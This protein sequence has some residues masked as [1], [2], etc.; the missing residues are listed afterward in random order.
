MGGN[1]Y[2]RAAAVLP[3]QPDPAPAGPRGF[4]DTRAWHEPL[5]RFSQV[6]HLTVSAYNAQAERCL[7]PYFEHREQP[8]AKMLYEAGHWAPHGAATRLER[9]LARRAMQDGVYCKVRVGGALLLAAMP[10]FGE[11]KA[12]VGALVFGWVMG[13]FADPLVCEHLARRFNLQSAALWRAARLTSPVSGSKLR[14]NA[15]LLETL[16]RSIAYQVTAS[17]AKDTFLATVSHE[18]RT[19][20]TAMLLRAQGLKRSQHMTHD[21]DQRAL[22]VIL[23]SASVQQKLIE[24]LLDASRS[25]AGNLI[26]ET[27][28]CD[29]AS[30]LRAA[31]D[32]VSTA[33]AAK[34]I[35]LNIDIAHEPLL[36]QAD[37]VR[38]QQ[39]F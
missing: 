10:V 34:N 1:L 27:T 25:T 8:L 38:L 9:R 18:L 23:Q 37:P 6:T 15:L 2:D 33:A 35:A 17:R 31:L 20:L 30:T 28:G 14:T 11:A 4:W 19:P 39:L 12:A 24:D 16:A 22:A 29:V 7:G 26:M 21:G 13:S 32:V 5:Q 36:R 3:H